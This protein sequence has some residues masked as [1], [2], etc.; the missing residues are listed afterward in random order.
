MRRGLLFRIVTRLYPLEFRERFGREMEAAYREARREAGARGRHGA[1]QIWSGVA[2][3]ALVRA[4]GQHM[5]MLWY[6]LRQAA[7]S[8]RRA[9]MFALIAI[10]TLAL[11]IG[12]N[13]A[14][15]SIVHA[16]ALEA[17]PNR[18]PERLVRLWEKN[19]KLRIPRFSA[20]V[21]NY[22]SWTERARSFEQ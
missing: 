20:S 8:L 3:D 1:L 15:F 18:E 19:D 14:I 10:A 21:P 7:R 4:P 9:R 13:T 2:L 22:Y 17:L 11:G 16:V 12:A 5:R 6:D